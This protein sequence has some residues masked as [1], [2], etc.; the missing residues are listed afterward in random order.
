MRI[1]K[2]NELSISERNELLRRPSQSI[3]DGVSKIVRDIISDI[4]INRDQALYKYSEFI[5]GVKLDELFVTAEEIEKAVE[6]IDTKTKEAINT[7]FNNI[8]DFHKAQYPL[9]L[10]IETTKGI[11]VEKRYTAIDSV[12]LYIPSSSAPLFSSVLMLGVPSLIA[13]CSER[14]IATCPDKDGNVDPYILYS[15]NLVGITKILKLSGAQA[16]A[17]LALGT[18]SSKPVNKIFGPGNAF[19]TEAKR[20]LSFEI[21]GLSIDL[22]AGPS[23]LLVIAESDNDPSIIAADLLSQAEHDINSQII[24][25]V[26]SLSFAQDI[27]AEVAIQLE[28][29]PRKEIARESIKKSSII[30]EQTIEVALKIAN[31]YAPEHLILNIEDY[32]DFAYSI[33][34]AGSVFLGK[35]SSESIGDYASGSNH[36]LPTYGFSK[37]LGGL[38]L[39]SF[40]K[41][42]TF[43]RVS[44]TGFKN[45]ADTVELLSSL[46]K[47]EAH[48]NA[49]TVRRKLF[50]GSY[51]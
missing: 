18:N 40:M 42:S 17:A 45:I 11:T 37:S 10:K 4:R 41:A 47:L 49:I 31:D 46:E 44:K 33:K 29:L 13:G 30:V 2:W 25:I 20:Q 5:D 7:A 3:G 24:C 27:N 12:G 19:V 50:G 38:D 28:K 1:V 6:S 43:Q 9:P 34:N 16:I 32:E 22:P 15:A 8:Y 36:V 26:E 48:K 51:E 21:D 23:E 35:Y 14:I 39:L